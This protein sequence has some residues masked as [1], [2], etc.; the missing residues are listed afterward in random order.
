MYSA[1]QPIGYWL[2]HLDQ[3]IEANFDRT[4]AGFGLGRRHW[5]TLNVLAAGPQNE[6]ALALALAPFWADVGLPRRE[7]VLAELQQ[8]G[9]IDHQHHSYALTTAGR[10]AHGQISERVKTTR[11]QATAGLSEQEY[12]SAISTLARMA[13]N[14]EAS[15]TEQAHVR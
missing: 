12:A 14:L 6:A 4:L 3:L 15:L 11:R 5:Q 9:W 10:A 7:Q 13:A 1:R 2:K 8:R